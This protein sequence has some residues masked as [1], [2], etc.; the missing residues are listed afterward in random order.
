MTPFYRMSLVYIYVYV[1]FLYKL[2][3]CRGFNFTVTTCIILVS[4]IESTPGRKMYVYDAKLNTS[5][6]QCMC[7]YGRKTCK[8]KPSNICIDK[9]C[10]C[11]TKSWKTLSFI[12]C[13]SYKLVP[14]MNVIVANANNRFQVYHDVVSHIIG[15]HWATFKLHVHIQ[16]LG[17]EVNRISILYS[18]T[19]FAIF[20]NAYIYI[21][22]YD[23]NFC[24]LPSQKRLFTP[25]CSKWSSHLYIFD[26]LSNMSKDETSP[27]HANLWSISSLF[28]TND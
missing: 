25:T 4:N 18:L 2:L 14:F 10:S 19:I 11:L 15:P 1:F 7:I 20:C 28:I 8:R 17:H 16:K 5:V 21:L 3:I 13:I 22:S 27:I 26:Y 23:T 24:W 9:R 12:G 6:V